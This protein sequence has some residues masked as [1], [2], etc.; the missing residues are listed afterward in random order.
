M[1][2]VATQELAERPRDVTYPP[3]HPLV[4]WEAKQKKL[5]HSNKLS[6][7][8]IDKLSAIKFSWTDGKVVRSTPIDHVV[9]F[10][11][12]PLVQPKKKKEHTDVFYLS[13]LY[14]AVHATDPPTSINNLPP[15]RA[16]LSEYLVQKR[17]EYHLETIEPNI[18]IALEKLGINWGEPPSWMDKQP[19]SI[20]AR[21][22]RI[23]S[24]LPGS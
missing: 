16:E 14:E 17:R 15:S 9:N 1:F 12:A 11:L 13:Q 23:I 5:Y 6:Q 22:D 8:K 7:D 18:R 4:Q 21:N 10:R 20:K 3:N 24:F 19:Q 2:K